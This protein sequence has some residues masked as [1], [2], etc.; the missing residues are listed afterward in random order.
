MQLIDAVDGLFEQLVKARAIDAGLGSR[1]RLRL[2]HGLHLHGAH[3]QHQSIEFH[4]L[5]HCCLQPVRI[6]TA[7]IVL[8]G[9]QQIWCQQ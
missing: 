2:A 8:Q 4:T 1:H 9:I 5:S 7:S 6:L 3:L